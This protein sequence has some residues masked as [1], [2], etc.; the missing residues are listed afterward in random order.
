MRSASLTPAERSLRSRLAAHESWARTR[1]PAA[2]TANAR[3]AFRD[4]FENEV[5]PD[6]ILDPDERIR[7]AES[8]RKAYFTRLALKSAT[9]RRRANESRI[10]ASRL[11]QEAT[12]ADAELAE[13]GSVAS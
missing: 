2:R 4:R 1:D 7:R 12:Q 11:E 6:G 9:S 10:D 13:L 5:D 3:K 8:A